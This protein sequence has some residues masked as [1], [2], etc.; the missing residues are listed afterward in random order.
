[1]GIVKS[2]FKGKSLDRIFISLVVANSFVAI[3]GIVASPLNKHYFE[4]I[5]APL[6]NLALVVSNFLAI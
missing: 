4:L 3:N 2:P 6:C 1:M 5:S